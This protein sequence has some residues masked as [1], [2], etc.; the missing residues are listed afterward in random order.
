MENDLLRKTGHRIEDIGRTLS[1]G[2]FGAFITNEGPETALGKEMNPDGYEW[3]QTIKTNTILAD[4]YDILAM[5]NANIVALASGK[6]TQ[7]PELYPRPGQ[8]KKRDNKRFGSGDLP[9]EELREWIEKRRRNGRH[10]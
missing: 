10:D 9:F 1:W 2:A 8:K 6:K 5:I 7:A 4:I 3:S